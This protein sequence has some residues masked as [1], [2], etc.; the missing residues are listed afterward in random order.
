[1]GSA[2]ADLAHLL[3]ELIENAL[4]FSP[5]DQTVEI[6]GRAQ[7]AGYT[8]AVID[9][10]LGMPPEELARANRRLA[11]AESFT[12]APSKYLGHYVAGNLAARHNINVTL[13]NSPGHGITATIN[14]PP[15][16]LTPEHNAIGGMGAPP[17]D[18]PGG[19]PQLHS[20]PPMPAL[21]SAPAEP[22]ALGAG[23]GLFD[24]GQP[25]GGAAAPVLER[26]RPAAQTPAAAPSA[27]AQAPPSMPSPG[28]PWGQ[29][30][31]VPTAAQAP[32]VP[33]EPLFP[34]I[35]AVTGQHDLLGQL[36]QR[37]SPNRP[38]GPQPR[39][40]LSAPP[41]QRAPG[42]RSPTQSSEL[43]RPHP[44]TTTGQHDMPPLSAPHLRV[45]ATP[46]P[47]E[48]PFRTNGPVDPGQ[49]APNPVVSPAA[50]VGGM[51]A[52]TGPLPQRGGPRPSN[53][54]PDRTPGGLVKRAPRPDA[55]AEAS[56][57]PSEDLLQ[58]LATYT[59][60]LHRQLPSNRPPTPPG[61]APPTAFPTFNPTPH[62]GTPAVR[63]GFPS[64]GAP[65]APQ[66]RSEP[67]GTPTMH[68]GHAGTAP[69]H[70]A[71][72]LARRVRGAQ[73]PQ[74]QP[75]GL[76]RSAPAPAPAPAPPTQ[77]VG[78]P[79][80]GG[81]PAA[82]PADNR[83]HAGTRDDGVAAGGVSSSDANAQS[84][85]AKDVYSFLSSFSAG[86]QRGLDEA[87][88]DDSTTSEED[89]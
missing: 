17:A 53:P 35:P 84:R 11:G 66:S 52:P 68:S 74:T 37:V 10:G 41:P 21:P 44:A 86:V 61:G 19:A 81:R 69:D 31:P 14:L 28:G 58:T 36:P 85:S 76:R 55:D 54:G 2:A 27:P 88:G 29:P 63:P 70:T 48:A 20:P 30:E 65:T 23:P 73:L 8:L 7:P 15:T 3:A 71:S 47:R 45:Q 1:M 18:G 72:G 78:T 40:D 60:Q 62:T 12:I 16:I 26:R 75:V 38:T 32:Q 9:S 80:L 87:R 22:A 34:Q 51:Q 39:L 43:G 77:G 50:A 46:P 57:R 42:G 13:H 83:V 4:I 67:H 25:G 49:T 79:A 64:Q 89:K 5:P 24:R 56:H 59:T 33:A 6:R 82:P